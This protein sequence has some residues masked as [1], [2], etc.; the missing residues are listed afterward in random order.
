IGS[1]HK[2]QA[3]VL[4]FDTGGNGSLQSTYSDYGDNVNNFTVGA[5]SYGQGNFFTPDVQLAYTSGPGGGCGHLTDNNT[6]WGVNTPVD[7]LSGVDGKV[8]W[9]AFTPGAGWGVQINSFDI[10]KD[11]GESVEDLTPTV[12]WV[13][14][15]DNTSGASLGFGSETFIA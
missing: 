11:G 15:Q 5:Y 6:N 7:Y 14:R 1:L 12:S 4:T 9:F 2:A 3:T 10:V 13:L 8:F